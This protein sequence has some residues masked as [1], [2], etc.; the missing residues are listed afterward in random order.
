MFDRTDPVCLN[1]NSCNNPP[2]WQQG[3]T[4]YTND[5]I[6]WN[7]KC[8]VMTNP[9]ITCERPDWRPEIWD[10]VQDLVDCPFDKDACAKSSSWDFQTK[11]KGP[12]FINYGECCYFRKEGT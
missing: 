11:Y 7:G 5:H 9:S 6:C 8:W 10:Y 3:A 12:I 2:N 1:R 4:Y